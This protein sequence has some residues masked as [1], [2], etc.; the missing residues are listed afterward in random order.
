MKFRELLPIVGFASSKDLSRSQIHHYE[1]LQQHH[2]S[3]QVSD[4]SHMTLTSQIPSRVTK[5][6][7]LVHA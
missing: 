2:P 5:E 7:A 3:I 4:T 1:S 6:F